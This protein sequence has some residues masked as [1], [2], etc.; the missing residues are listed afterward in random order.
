MATTMKGYPT[1]SSQQE[2]AAE[3]EN[4]PSVL[5]LEE[6]TDTEEGKVIVEY[7]PDID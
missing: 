4:N 2:G 5:Q 1:A 6:Q 3:P 7:K